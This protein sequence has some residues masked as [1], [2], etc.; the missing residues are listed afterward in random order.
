MLCNASVAGTAQHPSRPSTRRAQLCSGAHESSRD[1]VGLPEDEDSTWHC[2]SRSIWCPSNN[3]SRDSFSNPK[4]DVGLWLVFCSQGCLTIDSIDLM[5]AQQK[6]HLLWPPLGPL[7]QEPS[8]LPVYPTDEARTHGAILKALESL[9]AVQAQP[10]QTSG[11]GDGLS[12]LT[13]L[14]YGMYG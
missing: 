11:T 1:E 7:F 5:R 12:C 3:I 10:A 4:H 9:Q 14:L 13:I 2:P 6:R 8:P